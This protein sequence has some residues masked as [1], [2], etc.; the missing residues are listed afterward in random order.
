MTTNV[1]PQVDRRNTVPLASAMHWIVP[2]VI[3][4]VIR[5]G[6]E[7]VTAGM[8]SHLLADI[9][10]TLLIASL[11]VALIEILADARRR[12]WDLFVTIVVGLGFVY[13][14]VANNPLRELRT[15]KLVTILVILAA[16][17]AWRLAKMIGPAGSRK[18]DP[19][20]R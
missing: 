2:A 16:G 5:P 10:T 11:V 14:A 9:T 15:W 8:S 3:V 13:M 12:F 17:S 6:N 20:V 18:A 1:D 19:S 4:I 7:A